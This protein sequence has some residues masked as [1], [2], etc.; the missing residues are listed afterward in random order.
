[1][2]FSLKSLL[3]SMCVIG[4]TFGIMTR[5]LMEN[6]EMFFAVLRVGATLGPFLL[7]VGTII[8]IGLRGTPR[9]RGLAMWGCVLLL[10]PVLTF[11]AMGLLLPSGNPLRVLTTQRLISKRLPNQADEPWVWQELERRLTAGDLT[12]EEVD[13]AVRELTAHMKR[14][15][16]AGWNEPLSWQQNFLK[17][18]IQKGMISEPV[19]LALCDAFFGPAPTVKM[20]TPALNEDD[21]RFDIRLEY[22]TPWSDNSGLDVELV[23]DIKQVQLD[24]KPVNLSNVQKH[25]GRQASMTAEAELTPGEHKLEVELE[26]AYVDPARLLGANLDMLTADQWPKARKRWV[27]KTMVPVQ[28]APAAVDQKIDQE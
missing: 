4:A 2:K 24:G 10:T 19:F 15:K 27:A 23:W 22:G 21:A 26:C 3:I 16:P 20:T 6:P 11:L 12:K 14:T 28:V 13:D 17:P 9:R 1:M 8:W 25:F 7:A 18:A 5:L